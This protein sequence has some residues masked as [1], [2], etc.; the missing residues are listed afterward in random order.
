LNTR[1]S[2]NAQDAV[3]AKDG[4]TFTK[5]DIQG[6]F[7]FEVVAGST[8]PL[9]SEQKMKAMQFIAEQ[10]QVLGLMPGGPVMQYLGGEYA[11]EVDLPGLKKAMLEEAQAAMQQKQAQ[12]KQ[13]A[14]QQQLMASME[15][16]KLQLKA[17][18]EASK[19]NDQTLRAVE[20]F[21]PGLPN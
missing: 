14:D 21:H 4:F 12:M 19:Q 9:N 13:A 7:D 20:M 3:T 6:E 16:S 8:A 17:E 1:P 10:A 18:R 15:A 11:D 5:E 2:A